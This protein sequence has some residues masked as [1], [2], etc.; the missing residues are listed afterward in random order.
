MYST[1]NNERKSVRAL[2]NEIYKYMT[3]ISKNGNIDKLDDIGY[4]TIHI[5]A[6]SK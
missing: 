4:I 3:S 5:T 1:H 6:Q 2:K